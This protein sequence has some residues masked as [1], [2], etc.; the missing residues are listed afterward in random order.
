MTRDEFNA[1]PRVTESSISEGSMLVTC[2]NLYD[3]E[4]NPYFYLIVKVV[5]GIPFEENIGVE[6]ALIIPE[7]DSV[8]WVC[9]D[10]PVRKR[11][12]YP[13]SIRDLAE[14][15]RVRQII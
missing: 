9:E 10:K 8:Y 5:K 6:R 11:N 4:F 13:I 15:P 14:E 1:L 3:G 2:S 7:E 12:T